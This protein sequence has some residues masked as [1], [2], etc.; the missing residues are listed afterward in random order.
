M[1]PTELNERL[2][3]VGA[4][5]PGGRLL[6]RYWWP[7]M[8]TATLVA[9]PVQRFRL[10]GEDLVLFR[11]ESGELGVVAERCPHRGASL[12]YGFTEQHGLRCPYH[13]WLFA[14]DGTCVEQPNQFVDTPALRAQCAVTA[15]PAA[16]L[17]G[18]VFVYLGPAPAPALPPF[19]LFH[20][21]ESRTRFRDIGWAIVPC[22][23][24]QIMEN[25]LDP[26]HAEWLHGKLFNEHLMRAG[27]ELTADHLSGAHVKLAFD[28]FSH[29]IIKRRLRAGQSEDSDDWRVGH[30]AVFP[31]ILKIG[32]TGRTA[33]QIRVPIDDERTLHFWYTWYD[34]TERDAEIVSS[35]QKLDETYAVQLQR[36]DGS[37]LVDTID[38]QDAMVWS[39]QGG[40]A[41]RR[42]EHLCQGDEGVA[43]FRKLLTEQ[44]DVHEAGGVPMNVW[45]KGAPTVDLPSEH[46]DP[47]IGGGR[48]NPLAPYLRTHAKFSHRIQAAVELLDTKLGLESTR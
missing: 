16:E 36:P 21:T 34:L 6:R 13:G 26:T 1:I 8:T 3:R 35:V 15:Y 18:L 29:G 10:L 48:G 4:T 40:L 12:A 33:F 27:G 11:D 43:L 32:G 2:T 46:R 30:P 14:V 24:L 42:A 41:D 7:V 17:G 19:D 23:W 31:N 28:P 22:N 45:P 47:G 37:F 9:E 20:W 5:A 38:G 44:L 39:T 25:A